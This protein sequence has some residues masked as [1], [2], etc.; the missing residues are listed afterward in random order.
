MKKAAQF[1]LGLAIGLAM[2]SSQAV[3]AQGRNEISGTVFG[4]SGR[5]VADVFVELGT[6]LGSSLTRVRTDPSGRF[7]FRGLSNGSYSVKILPYGTDY[8]EQTQT[9]TLATISATASDR[10][11]LQI[12]LSLNERSRTGPF[13]LVP[14]VIFAQEVPRAAQRLYDEGV[15]HLAEKREADGLSSLKKAIET[16]P[17][18]YLAL[19]RLGAEYAVRGSSDRSYLEA[20]LV[21]LTRASE[22]NPKGFSSVF[23]LG[24]VQYHLGLTDQAIENLRRATTLSGKAADAYLWLGKALKRASTLDQA[25]AAFKR[26]NELTKG[27][28]A[29]V[30]WQTAGLYHDQKR[31]K[32]AADEFELFLKT[33]PKSTDAEKIRELI[34]QLREKAARQQS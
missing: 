34:R 5:P 17:T 27:K 23:G 8:R 28:S 30:H 25:E 31:Y 33:Q 21:L 18:Y 7:T 3:L 11:Q 1:V 2:A 13:A 6:D 15:R 20:G 26:A 19:D 29:E 14:G 32:E 9:V 4:E 22:V 24:W 16:F 10:Q 12:Y